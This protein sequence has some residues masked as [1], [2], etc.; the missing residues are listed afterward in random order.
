MKNLVLILAIVF[1]SASSFAQKRNDLKGPEFKNFKVWEST[2]EPTVVLVGSAK[3]SLKGP[4][5]KNYKRWQ[6]NN[7]NATFKVLKIESPR[8]KLMGL[9][10]KNYKPWRKNAIKN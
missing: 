6:K 2:A 7:K 5:F 9:A 1:I 4:A 3:K 10:Y 8:Q